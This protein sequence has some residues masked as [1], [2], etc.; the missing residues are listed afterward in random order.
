MV[1]VTLEAYIYPCLMGVLGKF[2]FL[3]GAFFAY[4]PSRLLVF[5]PS[6]GFL[7]LC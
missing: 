5:K 1:N 3:T 2:C 6:L 4:K 7:W